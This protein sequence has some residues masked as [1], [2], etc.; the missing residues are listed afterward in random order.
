MRSARRYLLCLPGSASAA[1][2]AAGGCHIDL[3]VAIVGMAPAPAFEQAMR[4]G[5][6]AEKGATGETAAP[7]DDAA[8]KLADVQS[9]SARMLARGRAAAPPNTAHEQHAR[10]VIVFQIV[11]IRLKLRG[12]ALADA[13]ARAG[14]VRNDDSR[15]G[16]PCTRL[17]RFRRRLNLFRRRQ[18]S[19]FFFRFRRCSS[20][21]CA[22]RRGKRFRFRWSGGFFDLSLF[23]L[24]SN[25][26][27]IGFQPALMRAGRRL[28]NNPVTLSNL[29]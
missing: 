12:K 29:R 15:R 18:G 21:F 1:G 13:G 5:D 2:A 17:R 19:N 26:Q 3:R 6:P 7:V 22:R 8:T 4:G 27:F 23:R 10:T 24:R 16:M 28:R 11:D 25:S 9:L 20:L 14:L